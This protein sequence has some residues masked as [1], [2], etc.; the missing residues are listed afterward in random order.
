M[1]ETPS[2]G[3]VNQLDDAG[4]RRLLAAELADGLQATPKRISPAWFYDEAGSRL[5]E[6]ITR[7]PEYYLSRAE[8][9]CLAERAAEIVARS[10]ATTLVE[11][12]SGTSE[13]TTLLLDA[14]AATGRLRSVTLLDISEEVLLSA[15]GELHDLYGVEVSAV[16]A[17]LRRDLPTISAPGPALWAFLGSTIGNFLPADRLDLLARF[18]AAMRPGDCLLL[19]TDL[20][21]DP[22]R[23][24]QA[25]DDRAG[26]TAAFNL[27]VLTVLNRE[28]GA[29]FRADR[30]EHRAVWNATD[31]WIE[32][33]LRSRHSQQVSLPALGLSLAIAEGEEILTEI[34]AKFRP[35]TVLSELDL[36]DLTPIVTW[37]DRAGDMLLTM[38]RKDQ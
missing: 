1:T 20:E 34:S 21:K 35:E 12:G 17:D 18:A 5:F 23:L 11:I 24:V 27:N 4:L 9:S 2:I 13:K 31:R 26:V 16:V 25:Y 36:A 28:M 15:A 38:A 3:V 37:T 33:R 14:M 29:D 30:F 8:T 19:G 6:Q 10:A 32:M 22:S 7:L